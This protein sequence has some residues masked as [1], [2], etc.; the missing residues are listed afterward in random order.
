MINDNIHRTH[1]D[2]AEKLAMFSKCRSFKMC[3]LIVKEGRIVSIGLNGTPQGFINCSDKFPNF[4][5]HL[6]TEL[7]TQHHDWSQKF[8]I[9]A[10]LNAILNAAKEGIDL[11][12]ATMY[13][14]NL[15]CTNCLK[16]IV[17]AGIKLIV[18]R[19][20][21]D[22]GAKGREIDEFLK[23]TFTTLTQQC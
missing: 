20:D 15:C 17:A 14:T 1:L 2:I 13:I 7:R 4:D 18:Y 3:A 19:Y 12:N 16:H 9:H 5:P 11:R 6:N 10:E 8:E 22:K 23:I 21:Y